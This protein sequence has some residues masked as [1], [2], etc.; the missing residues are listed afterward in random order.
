MNCEIER[1]AWMFK[2]Q[3]NDFTTKKESTLGNS[4]WITLDLNLLEITM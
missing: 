2:Q 4:H 1:K 3:D